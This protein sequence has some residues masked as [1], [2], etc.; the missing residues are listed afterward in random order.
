MRTIRS[1]RVEAGG[2]SSLRARRRVAKDGGFTL[3]EVV[4]TI[5]LISLVIIP[6][7]QA[8]MVGIKASSTA[9]LIAEIDTTLQ[10]AADRVNRAPARC[11]YEQYMRAALTAKGWNPDNVSATYEHYKPGNELQVKDGPTGTWLPD[12]CDNN[13]RTA[14]LIQKVTITVTSDQGSIQRTIEVVKSDV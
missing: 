2:D 4:I 13:Q 5:T 6:I 10:N 8:T 14:R 3:V 9:R 12:A 11:E 1:K 7:I